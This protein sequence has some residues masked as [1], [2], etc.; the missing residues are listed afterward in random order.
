MHA[1]FGAV[2]VLLHVLV[3]TTLQAA[4]IAKQYQNIL[5]KEKYEFMYQYGTL[6]EKNK[7]QRICFYLK[8]KV[9]K[10]GLPRK[11]SQLIVG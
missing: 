8:H 9:F 10:K 11:V 5:D 4:E 3:E 1:V 2:D 6:W 7:A